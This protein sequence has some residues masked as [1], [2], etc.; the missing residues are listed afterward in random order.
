MSKTRMVQEMSKL[1]E[2]TETDGDLLRVTIQSLLGPMIHIQLD[3]SREPLVE[4]LLTAIVRKIGSSAD[5]MRLSGSGG[6]RLVIGTPLRS[7][8]EQGVFV[9]PISLI[10][11]LRGC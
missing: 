4:D 2:H 11:N 10:L 7:Y 3:L 5:L 8:H 9:K 1:G 6:V